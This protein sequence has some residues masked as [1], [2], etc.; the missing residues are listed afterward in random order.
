MPHEESSNEH[1]THRFG[2]TGIVGARISHQGRN[3]ELG[4][5]ALEE[6]VKEVKGVRHVGRRTGRAE[7]DEHAEG[8]NTTEAIV[9]ID[10]SAGRSRDEVR[11]EI[12]KRLEEEFPGVAIAVEQ[13]LAHLLSHLLSGVNA[14]VA[15]KVFGPDLDVLRR[16]TAEI[17]A[18]IRPIPGVTGLYTQP[19]VLI[20]QIAVSPKRERMAAVGITVH[21]IA[22]AIELGGGGEEISR[23]TVGQVSYPIVVRLAGKEFLEQQ[24]VVG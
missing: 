15:I 11:D 7:G 2:C 17:E 18:G 3:A 5:V 6:I 13:P 24:G 19:M 9:S 16:T 22:E 4:V 14:Q 8:V 20:D 1:E 21:D 12:Q 10:P 23:M